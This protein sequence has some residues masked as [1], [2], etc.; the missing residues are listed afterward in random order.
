MTEKPRH[1]GAPRSGEPG[2]QEPLG[3]MD[4]GL[5]PGARPG[6]SSLDDFITAGAQALD[7]ALVPEW[8]PAVRMNL[9]V[10]LRHAAF[11]GEFAL[12]DDAEPAPVFEA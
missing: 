7:L 10:T 2:I 4:S 3:N 9:Q 11:V 12:P 8:L 5:A 1:S 6:M